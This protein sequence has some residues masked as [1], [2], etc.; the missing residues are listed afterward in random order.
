MFCSFIAIATLEQMRAKQKAF[1]QKR[2]VLPPA[3]G[4]VYPLHFGSSMGFTPSLMN[5][6]I[7]K[8][9]NA[10]PN[11]LNARGVCAITAKPSNNSIATNITTVVFSI[12][13]FI[14]FVIIS[15]L[16]F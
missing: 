7:N 16:G 1:D 6:I 11:I 3:R 5:I 15:S 4:M 12:I 9:L 14:V 10:P 2:Y 13:F 8:A